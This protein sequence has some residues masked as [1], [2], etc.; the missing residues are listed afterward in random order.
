[1]PAL[2]WPTLSRAVPGEIEWGLVSNTQVFTS[3]LSGATQTMALPGARWKV[4]FSLNHLSR[5]DAAL[6]QAFFVRL[7]GMSGSFTLH[8]FERPTPRGS[9]ALSGVTVGGAVL[10]GA[11]AAD[12]AGC[13]AG[14]TL[15]T[16]DFI[17][18]GG[19]LKMVVADATADGAG[20]MTA[21]AF[22]PPSRADWANGAAVVT[23]KPLCTFMLTEDSYAWTTRAP[24]LSDFVVEA[25]E[26]I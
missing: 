23:N 13:G 2:T 7:R 22:E 15:L 1:M 8:N 3:P 19:E 17:G 20:L 14:A 10:A 5:E 4:G 26:R 12:L 21:V 25:M 24:L 18:I 9:C 6:L 11:T 16:G